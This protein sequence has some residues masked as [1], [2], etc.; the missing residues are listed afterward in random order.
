MGL[1]ALG[2]QAWAQDSDATAVD[3]EG[4]E[5][6]LK[7]GVNSVW[8]IT[9]NDLPNNDHHDP[10]FNVRVPLGISAGYKFSDQGSIMVE[11]VWSKQGSDY[12]IMDDNGATVGEKEINLDYIVVPL[13]LKY[14]GQSK[15]RFAFQIGAQAAFLLKGSETNTFDKDVTYTQTYNKQPKTIQKGSYLLASEGNGTPV[16]PQKHTFLKTDWNAIVD[17]GMEHDLSENCYLSVGLRLAYGFKDILTGEHEEYVYDPDKFTLRSNAT[18][19]LHFGVHW[20][21]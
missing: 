3:N 8:I 1:V 15:T 21:L 17:I 6:G 19:G 2:G 7:A 14:T 16:E 11:A 9:N 13:M 10:K 12:E 20:F 4:F 5:L 18:G